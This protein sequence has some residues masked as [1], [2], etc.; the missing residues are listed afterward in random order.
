MAL[1]GAISLG[2]RRVDNDLSSF[3]GVETE[4]CGIL[5]ESESVLR[6]K[7]LEHHNSVQEEQKNGLPGGSTEQEEAS[8][9]V[10]T[11]TQGSVEPGDYD[12]HNFGKDKSKNVSGPLKTL[13]VEIWY[14]SCTGTRHDGVWEFCVGDRVILQ[15]CVSGRNV[16][17]SQARWCLKQSLPPALNL[18][19]DTSTGAINGEVPTLTMTR[20]IGQCL[21]RVICLKISLVVRGHRPHKIMIKIRIVATADILS[22]FPH[23]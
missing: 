22:Q 4:I 20:E 19:F 6:V 2:G 5:G 17:L 3:K 7:R 9:A 12:L 10:H 11:P 8:T 14:Q 16:D 15:P 23:Y 1:G 13:N 21:F 18:Y